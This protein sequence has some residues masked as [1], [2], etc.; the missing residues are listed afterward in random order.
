MSGKRIIH[1]VGLQKSGTSLLVRLLENSG[2][3]QFLDGKGKT[4][5]G[6]LGHRPSFSPTDWPMG[7]IYQRSGGAHGH[8][9]G[10]EDATEEIRTAMRE[11]AARKLAGVPTPLGLSKIPYNMVRLPFV[12]AVLP[13]MFIVGVVRRPVANV[14]SL[15]KRFQPDAGTSPPEEGWWGVKPSGWRDLVSEDKVW[16]IARQWDRTNRK[17]W[18]DRAC[19]DCVVQ[20]DRLCADPNALVASILSGALGAAVQVGM[21]H[22]ALRSCD[23]EYPRGGRLLPRRRDWAD[24]NQLQL[25]EPSSPELAPFTA[26]QIRTVEDVCRET[27]LAMGLDNE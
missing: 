27:A 22:D 11:K 15:L 14:Y 16:Q 3:A 7:T 23:D 8:E 25:S 13:D 26:D 24:S 9:I 17:M 1:V 10:E 5:G 20:Y 4:E 6:I 12:R 19:L 18:D 2:H 21:E